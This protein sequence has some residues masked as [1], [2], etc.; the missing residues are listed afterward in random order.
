MNYSAGKNTEEIHGIHVS[1]FI[2]QMYSRNLLVL[3]FVAENRSQKQVQ[4]STYYNKKEVFYMKKRSRSKIFLL[5]LVVLVGTVFL[6]SV[7]SVQAAQT[8]TTNKS[9]QKAKVIKKKGTYNI[10]SKVKSGYIR[11]T[12]PKTATYTISV[13][14]IR[15]WGK[16]SSESDLV[17]QFW[18]NKESKRGGFVEPL[19]LK[20][21]YGQSQVF[22]LASKLV[23]NRWGNAG[24][25]TT[26]KCLYSRYAKV[27]LKKG[28]TVYI[29]TD[30]AANKYQC[31][32]KIT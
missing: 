3:D 6:A 25:N 29:Q 7:S 17:G 8:V 32:L 14:N 27:K 13:Y 30:M 18:V 20:T 11:F 12:A 10:N 15:N 21:N 28:E 16:N 1:L 23:V 4:E 26:G 9:W 2:F 19:K 5:M 31:T 24:R 22:P